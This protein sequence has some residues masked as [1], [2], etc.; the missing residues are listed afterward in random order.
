LHNRSVSYM[1][2]VSYTIKHWSLLTHSERRH[3]V[4]NWFSNARLS[5]HY[6]CCYWNWSYYSSTNGL[7]K[8]CYDF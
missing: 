6:P 4:P 8:D 3:Y 5:L 1:N 7:L 2:F